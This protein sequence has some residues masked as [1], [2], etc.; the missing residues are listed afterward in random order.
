MNKGEK[1][2]Y[3]KRQTHEQLE[4]FILNND[5]VEENL[6][7]RLHLLTGCGNFGGQDGTDGSCIDCYMT[8]KDLHQ[9]CCLFQTSAHMY[10]TQKYEDVYKRFKDGQHSF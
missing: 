1:R 9:R 3:L 6:R 7:D 5:M 2:D 10:I 8:N 4:I